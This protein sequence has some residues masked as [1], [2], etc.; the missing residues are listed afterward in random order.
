MKIVYFDDDTNYIINYIVPRLIK[1]LFLMIKTFLYISWL[2]K[3]S[4][5][6][7][8]YRKQLQ[9]YNFT[10]LFSIYIQIYLKRQSFRFFCIFLLYFQYVSISVN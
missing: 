7:Q 3:N 4:I 8:F 1:T 10:S 2:A 6:M 5:I 9:M